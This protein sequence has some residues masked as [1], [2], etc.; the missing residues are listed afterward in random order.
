MQV[1]AALIGLA[2]PGRLIRSLVAEDRSTEGVRDR[3]E[4]EPS[5]SPLAHET[6]QRRQ[7]RA[8]LSRVGRGEEPAMWP[9][10]EADGHSGTTLHDSG[11][12]PERL[13]YHTEQYELQ[14]GDDTPIDTTSN[15][16]CRMRL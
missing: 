1:V 14:K 8:G 10:T 15:Y 9:C 6:L 7:N 11:A 12:V 3:T 13:P 2:V 16:L 5:R 4:P